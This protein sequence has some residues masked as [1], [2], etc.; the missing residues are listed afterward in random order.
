M[1]VEKC[2]SFHESWTGSVGKPQKPDS[3]EMSDDA[4]TSVELGG[5]PC[6]RPKRLYTH[7]PLDN[8]L[9]SPYQ[10]PRILRIYIIAV[11]ERTRES[12]Y[13]MHTVQATRPAVHQT[14][15]SI[16]QACR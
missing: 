7:R 13:S 9:I 3:G 12:R 11:L 16:R 5:A 10:P 15:A 6:W 1:P 14:N 2:S 4:C 8:L